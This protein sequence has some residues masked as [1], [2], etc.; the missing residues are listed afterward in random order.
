MK[1]AWP[2]RLL[3][4]YRA[5]GGGIN[6]NEGMD[7]G[8][9]HRKKVAWTKRATFFYWTLSPKSIGTA[10]D[11]SSRLKWLDI[12]DLLALA[13]RA[14]TRLHKCRLLY[15]RGE[16]GGI[17]RMKDVYSAQHDHFIPRSSATLSSRESIELRL[18]LASV[19][20]IHE[21]G[22]DIYNNNTNV[23]LHWEGLKKKIPDIQLEDLTG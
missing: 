9:T 6:V 5:A 1:S 7:D 12:T 22:N 10:A 8:A 20:H 21:K 19:C 16:A 17:Y 3:F 13:V 18:L 15:W 23:T 14:G 2:A 4:Y 11:C